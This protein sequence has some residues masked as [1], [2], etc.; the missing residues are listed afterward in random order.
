MYLI[1]NAGDEDEREENDTD[2]QITKKWKVPHRVT[3]VSTSSDFFLTWTT[4]L[5][6][7]CDLRE[8]KFSLKDKSM[9]MYA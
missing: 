5:F 3:H 6:K 9:V 4:H 7:K 1:K 2:K 8:E